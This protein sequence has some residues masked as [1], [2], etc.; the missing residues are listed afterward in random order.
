MH[1]L[2]PILA[3]LIFGGL[4]YSTAYAHTTMNVE[5]YAIEIGWEIEPPV[6]GLRNANFIYCSVFPGFTAFCS[7]A[8]A[9]G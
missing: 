6:V 8:G 9:T 5:Q 7:A 2:L 4:G 1:R 3:I